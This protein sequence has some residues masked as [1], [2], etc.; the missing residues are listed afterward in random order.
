MSMKDSGKGECD[1][2]GEDVGN[3]AVTECIVVGDLDPDNPGMVRN[4]HFCRK[5]GCD[6]KVLSARNLEHYTS[7][8]TKK[9]KAKKK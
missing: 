4:L 8:R 5:N 6:G 7:T 1:R 3:A 9:G 2:C